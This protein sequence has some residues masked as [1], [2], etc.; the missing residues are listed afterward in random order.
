MTTV[1]ILGTGRMGVRLAA[2]FAN[3]GAK[4]ILGERWKPGGADRYADLIAGAPEGAR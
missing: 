4:V 1:G 2:A 3:A